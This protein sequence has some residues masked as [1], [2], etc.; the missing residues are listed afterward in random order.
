ML[1]T[2]AKFQVCGGARWRGGQSRSIQ[3]H[4]VS[5]QLMC[6]TAVPGPLGAWKNNELYIKTMHEKGSTERMSAVSHSL[7]ATALHTHQSSRV[8]TS[9]TRNGCVPCVHR[10]NT[11]MPRLPRLQALNYLGCMWDRVG[12]QRAKWPMRSVSH[13]DRSR[14]NE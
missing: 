2:S 10:I 1:N 5:I 14:C 3:A 13:H 6:M 9:T 4:L 8:P 7:D 11:I 12:M